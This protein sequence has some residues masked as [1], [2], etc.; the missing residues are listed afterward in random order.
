MILGHR[1]DI[2]IVWQK[3]LTAHDRDMRSESVKV[4]VE[5]DMFLYHGGVL[6]KENFE[7]YR[8]FVII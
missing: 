3:V 2:I 8:T 4:I 1:I 6:V 7:K 5:E